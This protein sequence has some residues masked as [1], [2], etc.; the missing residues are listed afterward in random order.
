MTI[1]AEQPPQENDYFV[2]DYTLFDVV[3]GTPD[4]TNDESTSEA[5]SLTSRL[6]NQ[7]LALSSDRRDPPDPKID[8]HDTNNAFSSTKSLDHTNTQFTPDN[9][10]RETYDD[11]ITDFEEW[12]TSGAV[13]ITD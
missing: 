4:L 3:P 9:D 7:I 5:G 13:M 6:S 1:P 12:L 8:H 2:L 11:P 10:T